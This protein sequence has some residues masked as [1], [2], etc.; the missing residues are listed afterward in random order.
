[1]APKLAEKVVGSRRSTPGP[2]SFTA[3]EQP[4]AAPKVVK[5][6]EAD[7]QPNATVSDEGKAIKEQVVA[8]ATAKPAQA[9]SSCGHLA[10]SLAV[11]GT[12]ADAAKA[13]AEEAIHVSGCLHPILFLDFGWVHMV[14]PYGVA[15]EFTGHS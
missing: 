3:L 12:R 15:P 6:G 1:M 7:P 5:A 11:I 14:F 13:V 9:P 8:K 4:L 2:T 10:A